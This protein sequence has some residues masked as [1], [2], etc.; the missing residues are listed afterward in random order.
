MYLLLLLLLDRPPCPDGM[1]IL[2]QWCSIPCTEAKETL[3]SV[4]Y[5]L[6]ALRFISI[7]SHPSPG[8]FLSYPRHS[9]P[10]SSS[11]TAA[12]ASIAPARST[13][14]CSHHC[15]LNRALGDLSEPSHRSISDRVAIYCATVF[16][17]R[18]TYSSIVSKPSISFAAAADVYFH[19]Q[20]VALRRSFAVAVS[21]PESETPPVPC[22]C[23]GDRPGLSSE[24]Q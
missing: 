17:H 24:E 18:L 20:F 1:R 19:V 10:P 16:W 21:P 15:I 2:G 14:A 12:A 13:P 23:R 5:Y 7:F 4:P 6:I 9:S 3:D 11:D 22:P 8:V